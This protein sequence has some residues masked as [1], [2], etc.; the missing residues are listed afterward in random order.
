V[1]TG[2][3]R[4]KRGVVR[5]MLTKTDRVIVEGIN[6]VKRHQRARTATQVSSIIEREA[7]IHISNV[8]LIDPNSDK[9]TR[10][11]F[12]ERENGTLVRVGKKSGEDIE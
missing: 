1:L 5:R 3:D 9:P 2:K 8:R 12:R 10:V 7:G 6:M 4:G 11:T